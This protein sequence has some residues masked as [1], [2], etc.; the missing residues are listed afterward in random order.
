MFGADIWGQF[1]DHYGGYRIYCTEHNTCMELCW[2]DE[3]E[4]HICNKN[5]A[6][7]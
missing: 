1:A 6:Y 7:K 3:E 2:E 5:E 4:Q